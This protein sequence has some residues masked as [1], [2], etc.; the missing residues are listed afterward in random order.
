MRSNITFSAIA[1]LVLVGAATQ[2]RAQQ[3]TATADDKTAT[4]AQTLTGCLQK[5]NQGGG[6]YLISDTGG[7]W[8]VKSKEANLAPNVGHTVSIT[9]VVAHPNKRHKRQVSIIHLQLV[10]EGCQIDQP[11]DSEPVK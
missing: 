6:F 7:T 4:N 8:V 5:D 2:I 3:V 10:R 11:V 1:L 9:G